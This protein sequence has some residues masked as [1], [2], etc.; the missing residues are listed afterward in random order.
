MIAPR[1]RKKSATGNGIEEESRGD[2]IEKKNH[3]IISDCSRIPAIEIYILCLRIPRSFEYAH[4][5]LTSSTVSMTKKKKKKSLELRSVHPLN[6][7]DWIKEEGDPCN[8]I[9]IDLLDLASRTR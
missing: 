4:R 8:E 1:G 5:I 2:T 3:R 6:G 9:R 7:L